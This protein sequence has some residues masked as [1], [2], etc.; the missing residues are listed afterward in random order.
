VAVVFFSYSHKDEAL[1]DELEVHL[2][3]LKRQGVIETWHDRRIEA[4][5]QIDHVINHNLEQADIILL[6]VSPYFIAS[7]Y[8]YDVEMTRA[9]ERHEAGDARVIP[10]ILHPCDWHHL[11]FGK[12]LATPTDGKPISKFPNQHEAFLEVS[13]AIRDAAEATNAK[14]ISSSRGAP[15]VRQHGGESERTAAVPQARSSNL[16]IKKTFTD[17]DKNSFQTEAFEYIANYFEGSLT[18]LR[19]RNAEVETEYRRID[20]NQFSAAVYSRG[21]EVNACRISLGDQRGFFGGIVYSAGRSPGSGFNESLSIG[22]DGYT[23]FL[24]PLGMYSLGQNRDQKLSLE[25]A[26]EYYWSM[27]MQPLQR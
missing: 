19:S 12:L 10:V 9:L 3:A 2:S 20:A 18:E 6:L 21:S 26:A 15:P 16:R 7:D 22:D 13:T 5:Q 1:R 17:H 11:P 25:G 4:G 27:L 8:C 24:Q 23:L 14:S